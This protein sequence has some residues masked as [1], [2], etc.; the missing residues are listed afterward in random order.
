MATAVF[1]KYITVKYD[2]T[3]YPADTRNVLSRTF[4]D[5]VVDST[6]VPDPTQIFVSYNGQ[7]INRRIAEPTTTFSRFYYEI[8]S[9]TTSSF[10]VNI[11]ANSSYTLSGYVGGSTLALQIEDNDLFFIDYTH[12]VTL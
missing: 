12:T 1:N 2:T 6:N 4:N 9:H 8:T 10:T 3:N 7:R 5:S 11:Y